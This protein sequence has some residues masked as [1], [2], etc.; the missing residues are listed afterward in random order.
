MEC[1]LVENTL[2]VEITIFRWLVLRIN[3]TR[4]HECAILNCFVRVILAW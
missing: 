4:Y 2:G 3:F 1:E